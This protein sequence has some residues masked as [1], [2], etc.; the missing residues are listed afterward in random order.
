MNKVRLSIVLASYNRHIQL[1]KCLDS[2]YSV[3]ISLGYLSFIEIIVIDQTEKVFNK[4]EIYNDKF[5][6]FIYKRVETKNASSARNIGS[7]ESTGMYLWFIDDDAELKSFDTSALYNN[8]DILFISWKE[9]SKVFSTIYPYN[10]LNLLR[11]SGTPFYIIRKSV[12]ESVSGFNKSLGPGSPQR[13]G[14][15]LDLLL[16][17]NRFHKISNFKSF[18]ELTHALDTSDQDKKYSYFH[19][20][21]F[22]LA[23]NREYSLFLINLIYDLCISSRDGFSRPIALVRGFFAGLK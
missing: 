7:T 5:T 14:E 9:K 2:I 11:R 12:F 6:N 23:S 16:R 20:R 8:N 1:S 21:G 15:D 17:I 13:G 3:F 19:A 18:G 4:I 22:V 10:K